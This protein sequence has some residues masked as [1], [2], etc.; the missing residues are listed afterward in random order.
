MSV[1]VN[2]ALTERIVALEHLVKTL[3]ADL[4]FASA[5]MLGPLRLREAVLVY[6]GRAG[7]RNFIEHIADEF[8]G[9]F[10]R[11]VNRHLFDLNSVPLDPIMLDI[12]RIAISGAIRK[13]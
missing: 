9:A 8:G 10:A 2:K 7:G 3:Q 6:V 1:V 5:E 11:E 13:R 4:K 12:M